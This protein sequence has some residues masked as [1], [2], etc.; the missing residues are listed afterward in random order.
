GLYSFAMA[1]YTKME[2]RPADSLASRPDAT[3]LARPHGC[4]RRTAHSR[5]T[6]CVRPAAPNSDVSA[7]QPGSC[8]DRHRTE[9][10]QS[11]LGRI[12]VLIRFFDSS[13]R[14]PTLWWR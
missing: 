1:R 12:S 8:R 13:D 4:R 9:N 14:H 7:V 5:G 11:T 2:V 10:W 3:I 6:E